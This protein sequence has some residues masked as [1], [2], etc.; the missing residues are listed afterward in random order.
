ML[1]KNKLVIYSWTG[2]KQNYF[3]PY[4]NT[5]NVKVKCY[6]LQEKEYWLEIPRQIQTP[7]DIEIYIAGY[8]RATNHTTERTNYLI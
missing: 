1:L 4:E 2:T 7:R 6:D 3:N 8:E 5:T